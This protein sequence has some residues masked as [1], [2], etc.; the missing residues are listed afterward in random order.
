MLNLILK[1][2]QHGDDNASCLLYSVTLTK[3]AFQRICNF[4]TCFCFILTFWPFRKRSRNQ[5]LSFVA[6]YFSKFRLNYLKTA[7][8]SADKWS[9]WHRQMSQKQCSW[10]WMRE[11]QHSTGNTTFGHWEYGVLKW[12]VPAMWECSHGMLAFRWERSIG[13]WM[14]LTFEMLPND[15]ARCWQT[16]RVSA[17]GWD[18][19]RE[20][21]TPYPE[22]C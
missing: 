15:G 3:F 18:E 11:R 16:F 4:C 9:T 21:S 5:K 14:F 22:P 10:L 6:A 1:T 8:L 7:T 2:S 12:N 20:L 13:T 19:F 17:D